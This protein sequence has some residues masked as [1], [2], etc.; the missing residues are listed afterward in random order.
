MNL[1]Y[2]N[3]SKQFRT[4]SHGIH[5]GTISENDKDSVHAT[6]HFHWKFRGR[7]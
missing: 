7:L 2:V 6:L 1:Y 5:K 3:N 4:G